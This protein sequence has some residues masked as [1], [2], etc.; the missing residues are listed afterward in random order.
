[1]EQD[2]T[3]L[4]TGWSFPPTFTDQDDGVQLTSGLEDIEASLHILLSTRLDERVIR[5][6]YG[7]NLDRL[8]FEPAT[9]NLMTQIKDLIYYAILRYEAR[10]KLDSVELDTSRLLEGVLLIELA[11]RIIATNSRYNYVYPFYLKEGT[12]LEL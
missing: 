2:K 11:Y 8:L 9:T 5:L 4:G 10:V 3:F 1:M 7:C 12:N 6:D